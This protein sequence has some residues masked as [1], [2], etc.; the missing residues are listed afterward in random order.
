M[1]TLET[2]IYPILNLGDF[3]ACYRL[4]KI[5]GLA[6]DHSEYYQN[7]QTLIR[8]ISYTLS[9]PAAITESGTDCAVNLL[10]RD[11]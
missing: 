6:R 2:N 8:E 7:T 9:T 5:R 1:S 4:Y 10:R 3:S 11:S